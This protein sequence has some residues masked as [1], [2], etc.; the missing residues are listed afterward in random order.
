MRGNI[1]GVYGVGGGGG[2]G[3]YDNLLYRKGGAGSPGMK[4]AFQKVR[5]G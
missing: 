1:H 5:Y 4:A 2:G 3:M